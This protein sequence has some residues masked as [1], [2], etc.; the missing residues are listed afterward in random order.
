[1]YEDFIVYHTHMTDSKDKGIMFWFL[2]RSKKYLSSPKC[3]DQLC[4]PLKLLIKYTGGY[5]KTP[6]A[7]SFYFKC[8]YNK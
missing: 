5:F 7:V 4:S 1:M 6:H 3:P 8:F 2:A